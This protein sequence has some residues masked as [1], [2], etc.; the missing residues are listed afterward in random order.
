MKTDTLLLFVAVLEGVTAVLG[1][2]PIADK[3]NPLSAGEIPSTIT[4][5]PDVRSETVTPLTVIASPGVK[6][7]PS[8]I[9][10]EDEP[11]EI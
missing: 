6:V 2:I 3:M 10:A 7:S 9:K 1:R 8:T 11:G 5:V 4:P